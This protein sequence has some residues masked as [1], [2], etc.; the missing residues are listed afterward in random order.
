VA[1]ELLA[2][3]LATAVQMLQ[4]LQLRFADVLV[5]LLP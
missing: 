1:R 4:L 5:A 2:A 3:M